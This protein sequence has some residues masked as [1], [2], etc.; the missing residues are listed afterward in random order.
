[1]RGCEHVAQVCPPPPWRKSDC[2]KQLGKCRALSFDAGLVLHAW[3]S[4]AFLAPRRG[5]QGS[6]SLHTNAVVDFA[7]SADLGKWHG[8]ERPEK[9]R[10]VGRGLVSKTCLCDA[11]HVQ[12]WDLK[13]WRLRRA[14]YKRRLTF[15]PHVQ[16]SPS[17]SAQVLKQVVERG[18]FVGVTIDG[19]HGK[20]ARRV[21]KQGPKW[22]LGKRNTNQES[23]TSF[24]NSRAADTFGWHLERKHG[25]SSGCRRAGTAV[26]ASKETDNQLFPCCLNG[27][28][29]R[30][31]HLAW[32]AVVWPCRIASFV[33]QHSVDLWTSAAGP[34][35]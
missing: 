20:K 7:F 11:S 19:P 34:P 32:K 25:N 6:R 15:K 4:P 33:T 29:T 3:G 21:K 18:Q 28:D 27:C 22:L 35:G 24:T 14:S 26:F 16:T 2:R 9:R 23:E 10:G 30:T 8:D 13:L 17:I 5:A 31:A 1:M 12:R